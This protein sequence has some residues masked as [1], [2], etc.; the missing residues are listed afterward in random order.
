MLDQLLS[1]VNVDRVRSFRGLFDLKRDIIALLKIIELDANQGIAVEED[2]FRAIFRGDEAK[3]LVGQLFDFSVH[4]RICLCVNKI[5]K[6]IYFLNSTI[7]QSICFTL[8]V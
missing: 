5:V 1:E 3:T 2:I 8:I 7:F 6:F 4:V